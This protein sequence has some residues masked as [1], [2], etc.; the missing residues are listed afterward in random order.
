MFCLTFFFDQLL[1]FYDWN[2]HYYSHPHGLWV[3]SPL[4]IWP[5]IGLM[6]YWL[7]FHLGLTNN[8]QLAGTWCDM[9]KLKFLNGDSMSSLAC[10]EIN[11]SSLLMT[12]YATLYRVKCF[13]WLL[14]V[15]FFIIIN[16][17]YYYYCY[18]YVK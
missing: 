6:G 17:I 7:R 13:L 10:K 8:F 14:K 16:I 1:G 9:L 3:N 2:N 12:F 15:F 4:R 5:K 18:Y 11:Q